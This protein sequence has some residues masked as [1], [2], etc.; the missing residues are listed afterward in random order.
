MYAQEFRAT[1]SGVVRD[2]SGAA[3]AKAEVK[4][5]KKDS[6][7]AYSTISN[8][9]GFYTIPYLIPGVLWFAKTLDDFE[10]N[11]LAALPRLFC[12]NS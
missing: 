5:V 1:L 12:D 10:I 2:Q 11:D 6:G 4:A 9:Q 7:Q 8:E 3:V